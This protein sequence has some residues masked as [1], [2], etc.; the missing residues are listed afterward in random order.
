MNIRM[1]PALV[2]SLAI[3]AAGTVDALC[4]PDPPP[5]CA[6]P[7]GPSAYLI[8]LP[9]MCPFQPG[10]HVTQLL[11]ANTAPTSIDIQC[12]DAGGGQYF[13]QVWPSSAAASFDWNSS[14]QLLVTPY[15][16]GLAGVQCTGDPGTGGVVNVTFTSP[17]GASVSTSTPVVCMEE[18]TQ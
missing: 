9:E 10:T 18:I 13:C 7:E 17:G 1:W 11:C 12:D 4:D 2:G 14:G 15:E 3:F 8:E 5:E 16:N 6:P